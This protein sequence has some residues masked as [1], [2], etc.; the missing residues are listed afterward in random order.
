MSDLLSGSE[1]GQVSGG[2]VILH[3]LVQL[4]LL[5]FLADVVFW[6]GVDQFCGDV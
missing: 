5:Q 3:L 2:L 1:R 4:A 6:L